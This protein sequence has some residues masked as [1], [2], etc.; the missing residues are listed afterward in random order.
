MK[1][2]SFYQRYLDIAFIDLV[3]CGCHL[4]GIGKSD[5]FPLTP[6]TINQII[7]LTKKVFGCSLRTKGF[8]AASSRFRITLSML[9]YVLYI[10]YCYHHHHQQKKCEPF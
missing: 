7:I 2:H 1:I 3:V 5:S 4:A 9:F 10:P 6:S 8:E